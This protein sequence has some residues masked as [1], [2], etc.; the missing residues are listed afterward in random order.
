MY[1]QTTAV[2]YGSG[3]FFKAVT[4]DEKSHVSLEK[5]YDEMKGNNA[6]LKITPL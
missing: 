1:R 6:S 3:G 2:L 5:L 4:R